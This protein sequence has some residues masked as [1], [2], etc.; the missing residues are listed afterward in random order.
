MSVCTQFIGQNKGLLHAPILFPSKKYFH[1]TTFIVIKAYLELI[2]TVY[3]NF[4]SIKCYL[5]I[6]T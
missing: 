4:V 3:N 6:Q 2:S 1:K 5:Y